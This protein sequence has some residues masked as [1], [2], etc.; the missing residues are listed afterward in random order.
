MRRLL[1]SLLAFMSAAIATAQ[2]EAGTF[3]LI[4]RFGVAWSNISGEEMG[5]STGIDGEQL[6]KGKTREGVLGGVD[7]QYQAGEQLALSV[8]AF[9]ARQGCKY[10]DTDLSGAAQGN[11]DVYNNCK[12]D[13]DYINIPL[14]VH[15]YLF[16]GFSAN[17][18]V[19]CGFLVHKN[20]HLETNDVTVNK[21]GSYT[22]SDEMIKLDIDNIDTH[23]FDLSIPIG[24]SYEYANVVLDLRYN[25]GITKI[26]KYATGSNRNKSLALTVGY[27]LNL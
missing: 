3:S 19:Q 2:P 4:P 1:F 22:Y 15:E 18:G 20:M 25:F 6:K 13:L 10:D 23:T 7:L 11:Y 5:F 8:G 26:F 27:K 17:I 9:Y 21:D 12:T 16:E 14:M 24:I